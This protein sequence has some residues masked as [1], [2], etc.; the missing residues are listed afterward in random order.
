MGDGENTIETFN[1]QTGEWVVRAK[2]NE[3]TSGYIDFTVAEI[4]QE[5][6][7]FGGRLGGEDEFAMN[8]VY[9]LFNYKLYPFGQKLLSTR[10]NHATIVSEQTIV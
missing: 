2:L 7:C 3:F 1:D 10:R 4:G 6:F 9:R 8:Q 5:T